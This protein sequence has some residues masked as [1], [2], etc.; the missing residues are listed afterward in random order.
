MERPQVDLVHDYLPG[1]NNDQ[2]IEY[3][4][5]GAPQGE[6]QLIALSCRP[7]VSNIQKENNEMPCNQPKLY[8]D[9]SYVPNAALFTS[10]SSS[11]NSLPFV[12]MA[13]SRTFGGIFQD[14]RYVLSPT[15]QLF[16]RPAT[17]VTGTHCSG[18]EL[19][20]DDFD[21]DF[22]TIDMNSQVGQMFLNEF[23][24]ERDHPQPV[25]QLPNVPSTQPRGTVW[26]WE[27]HRPLIKKMYAD[28]N[29]SL[30][31]VMGIMSETYAFNPT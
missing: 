19:A 2:R 10:S 21:Y 13:S 22:A 7:V 24:F 30:K 14:P 23:E 5:P 27:G 9:F 11:S 3:R 28:E 31:E 17:D 15:P 12:P 18:V 1:G 16:S 20:L 6:D 25:T 29:K 4:K 26:D 8:D